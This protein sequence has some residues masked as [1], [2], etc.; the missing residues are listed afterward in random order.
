MASKNQFNQRIGR[1]AQ[2]GRCIDVLELF[3]LHGA[4][5]AYNVNVLYHKVSGSYQGVVELEHRGYIHI[6]GYTYEN[7]RARG[8][9]KAPIYE[10]K[11][12]DQ[13]YAIGWTLAVEHRKV[14][15]LH[16]SLSRKKGA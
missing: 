3:R 12:K 11:N 7:I 14:E 1:M 8:S 2:I 10:L 9:K 16:L 15:A 4:L 5:T 13:C 6:T